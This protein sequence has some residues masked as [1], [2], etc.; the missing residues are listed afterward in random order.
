[1][2]LQKERTFHRNEQYPK[3]NYQKVKVN[4]GFE[5]KCK[6]KQPA[7][8]WRKGR[9]KQKIR[10]FK[11]KSK[12]TKQNKHPPPPKKKPIEVKELQTNPLARGEWVT[13]THLHCVEMG[14]ERNSGAE[15]CRVEK[16]GEEKKK[17]EK[18]KRGKGPVKAKRKLALWVMFCVAHCEFELWRGCMVYRWQCKAFPS[19]HVKLRE[20]IC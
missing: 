19:C 8:Q 15:Q 10:F 4:L 11:C 16:L 7:H 9:K 2:N 12:M 20:D 3:P 13:N 14:K 17:P 5:L 6:S 1:M 18:D